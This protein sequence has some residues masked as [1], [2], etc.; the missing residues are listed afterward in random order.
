ML[1]P[2]ADILTITLNPAVDISTAV[3]AVRADEKLRCDAPVLDPGG[4]GINVARAI[5]RTGGSATAFV[6]LAGFRGQQMAALLK[7][8]DIPTMVF[9]LAGETRLSLAVSDRQADTQY[10]FVMPGP[11]WTNNDVDAL[12]DRLRKIIA[13]G[14]QVVL[15][16]SQPPGV[17]V[18]F[19]KVLAAVTRS[20]AAV[21]TLDTSGAALAVQTTNEG[22]VP[23]V[24]RLDGAESEA[25][26]GRPLSSKKDVAEFA[27][28]LVES[29]HADAVILA[30]GAEG[31]VLAF[32]N[33]VLHAVTPPVPVVSKVGAGDSFVG[34]F[35]L[36][37]ATGA[38][39]MD[40]L[41][42]GTAAASAAVMSPATELCRDSDLRTLVP[43]VTITQL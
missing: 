23:D 15:S 31:S 4:G 29:G 35:T 28:T 38:D 41:R 37:R 2:I 22:A 14:M 19:P 5:C 6:A 21:L 33:T 10:R 18:G 26:A 34:A 17:P 13:P 43:Q 36:A 24:L 27:R 40:A 30:L 12:V 1:H 8:E 7:D 11:V 3:D 42:H 20:N 25:L 39:W 16:G 9:S 32:E